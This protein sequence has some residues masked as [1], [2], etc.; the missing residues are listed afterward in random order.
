MS[1][2]S[3]KSKFGEKFEMIVLM[4]VT[5]AMHR[6]RVAGTLW[7]FLVVAGV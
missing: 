6:R 7:G 4:V 2:L 5:G 3:I 1:L